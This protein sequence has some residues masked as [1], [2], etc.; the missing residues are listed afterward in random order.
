M[1]I[2]GISELPGS[3]SPW[4]FYFSS[5]WLFRPLIILS[6]ACTVHLDALIGFSHNA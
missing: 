3:C 2:K 4:A 6:I 5:M 1:R